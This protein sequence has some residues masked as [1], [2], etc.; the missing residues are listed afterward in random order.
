MIFPPTLSRTDTVFR[1]NSEKLPSP[2]SSLTAAYTVT[3]EPASDRALMRRISCGVRFLVLPSPVITNL[4]SRKAL[5]GTYLPDE[6]PSL[7]DNRSHNTAYAISGS[8]S[9]TGSPYSRPSSSA[10]F[11]RLAT[12]VSLSSF[13]SSPAINSSIF[14][15]LIP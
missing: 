2:L 10:R 1:P 15:G 5:S 6:D 13:L 14:S 9:L 12:S 4:E 11:M 3:S 8:V 7:P